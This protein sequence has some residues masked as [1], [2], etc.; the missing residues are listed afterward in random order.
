VSAPQGLLASLLPFVPTAEREFARADKVTSFFRLYQSGQKP[1]EAVRL[2]IR[3][4]DASDLIKMN[5][6][7]TIGVDRFVGIEPAEMTGTTPVPRG[8]P[9]NTPTPDRFANVALRTADIKYDVPTNTLASGEY[10]LSFEATA[11][12]T[13]IKRDVRFAVR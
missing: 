1:L 12:A 2:E 9:R 8:M 7:R 13:T 4:R 10:L 11:G 5:E 6:T 3:V